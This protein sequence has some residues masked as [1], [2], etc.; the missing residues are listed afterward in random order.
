MSNFSENPNSLGDQEK[1]LVTKTIMLEESQWTLFTFS[2]TSDCFGC[3]NK[4]S[5]HCLPLVKLQIV[6]G[7]RKSDDSIQKSVLAL[8]NVYIFPSIITKR[9]HPKDILMIILTKLDI[10]STTICQ[11]RVQQV[12]CDLPQVS[13]WYI[14]NIRKVPFCI[15]LYTMPPMESKQ[16]KA[17]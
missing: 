10:F 7:A 11:A 6:L 9:Q 5:G 1:Q 14:Y 16:V 2:K 17:I 13:Q 12:Y 3:P 4:F 15:I 8:S